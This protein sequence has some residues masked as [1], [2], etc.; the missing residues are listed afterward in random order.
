MPK[1]KEDVRHLGGV[2]HLP[3]SLTIGM[4]TPA[5]KRRDAKSAKERGLGKSGG[6]PKRT[7]KRIRVFEILQQSQILQTQCGRDG[8]PTY[9]LDSLD[10]KKR[11]LGKSDPDKER[12][13]DDIKRRHLTRSIFFN[14]CFPPNS[15]RA[16]YSPLAKCNPPNVA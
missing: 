7:F 1:A 13:D 15:N 10:H 9:I 4:T 2:R 5:R 16:K 14:N 3:S 6:C 12:R 11:D 8:I